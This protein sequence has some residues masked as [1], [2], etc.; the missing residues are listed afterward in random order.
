MMF[1]KSE[2]MAAHRGRVHFLRAAFLPFTFALVTACGGSDLACGAGTEQQG[3]QCVAKAAVTG[4][5]GKAGE[6]ADSGDA[7]AVDGSQGGSGGGAGAS[8]E[9]GVAD[10]GATNDIDFSGITSASVANTTPAAK[11]DSGVAVQ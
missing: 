7:A 10:A 8:H 2:N 11:P 9:G 3:D 6:A 4:A 1:T 5:G